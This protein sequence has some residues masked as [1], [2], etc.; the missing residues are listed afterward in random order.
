MSR[1]NDV[2]IPIPANDAW[3]ATSTFH[4]STLTKTTFA[5]KNLLAL[6]SNLSSNRSDISTRELGALMGTVYRIVERIYPVY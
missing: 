5:N 1:A 2:R 3:H 6:K 4:Q